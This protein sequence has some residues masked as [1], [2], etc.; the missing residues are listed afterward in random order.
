MFELPDWFDAALD[1]DE[2]LAA[3][4]GVEF[5]VIAGVPKGP[6]LRI[7]RARHCGFF[8]SPRQAVTFS[9]AG[10][11]DVIAVSIKGGGPYWH[12]AEPDVLHSNE[13]EAFC[14]K[15]PQKPSIATGKLESSSASHGPPIDPFDWTEAIYSRPDLYFA[16]PIRAIDLLATV[17]SDAAQELVTPGATVL[18]EVREQ[19]ATITDDGGGLRLEP[20]GGG[21]EPLEALFALLVVPDFP[22]RGYLPHICALSKRI[23]VET[24]GGET[25]RTIS[26]R[27]GR[28]ADPVVGSPAA[29]RSSGTSIRFIPDWDWLGESDWPDSIDDLLRLVAEQSISRDWWEN[30]MIDRITVSDLRR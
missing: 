26:F 1:R 28:V 22:F 6:T 14:R 11:S 4:F 12:G 21:R 3:E 9:L 24:V 16:Q 13:L 7:Y 25:I 17:V 27:R 18:V 8:H 30:G 19:E 20:F 15:L 2:A 5:A 10:G 29:G 23:E